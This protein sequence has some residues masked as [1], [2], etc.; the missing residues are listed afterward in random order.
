MRSDPISLYILYHL[1][2]LQWL[3]DNLIYLSSV[4][5]VPKGAPRYLLSTALSSTSI[6]IEWTVPHPLDLD[7]RLTGYQII[8][9]GHIIDTKIRTIN[10]NTTSIDNQSQVLYP[11]EDFTLYT[12]SVSAKTIDLGIASTTQRRTQETSKFT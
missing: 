9:Y 7:G 5:L 1:I 4:S 2:P 12:I 8:Y 10:I 6:L 3:T 11:L